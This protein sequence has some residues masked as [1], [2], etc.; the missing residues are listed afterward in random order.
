MNTRPPH[1]DMARHLYTAEQ[2]S[3]L[4]RGGNKLSLL[5]SYFY[6]PPLVYWL[7]ALSFILLGHSIFVAVLVNSI[8]LLI[9]TVAFAS[10]AK[11]VN[12][13]RAAIFALIFFLTL[14]LVG[15]ITKEVQLDLPLSAMVATN[16]AL[17]IKTKNFS[18]YNW[19]LLYGIVFGLGM[20]TK[21]TFIAFAAWPL[22]ISI[23]CILKSQNRREK[24]KNLF[25]ASLLIYGISAPW[26]LHNYYS[27]RIDFG[28][29]ATSAGVRE[30][31]PAVSSLMGLSWYP[32]YILDYYLRLP[33]LL[34]CI[35]SFYLV[36]SKKI[37]RVLSHDLLLILSTAVGGLIVFTFLRNKDIRYIMPIFVG[38]SLIA[39]ITI[40][41][42]ISK[43]QQI[44]AYSLISLCVISYAITSFT[45]IS[46]VSNVKLPMVP[47][48]VWS[49]AGYI[50]GAPAREEW[51]L[52]AAFEAIEE[53]GKAL[54]FIGQDSIWFNDWAVK[55]YASKSNMTIVAV[56]D[57][58]LILDRSNDLPGDTIWSCRALDGTQV[59][60]RKNQP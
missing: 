38:V 4:M 55:Y 1:W 12:R 44:L 2:Y 58:D 60:L 6:Y 29:N 19:S 11:T 14:P 48:T 8:W 42:L 39:G 20:L 52:A 35:A 26:Y 53:D 54:A 27:L 51:C 10:I 3:G 47:I 46:Q 24:L 49:G 30:G 21:W 34:I 7:L 45:T 57:A 40:D 16:L 33:W 18:S 15:S 23:I 5:L 31:D 9:L 32:R 17:I 50:T 13:S 37:K 41:I 36:L 59:S 22:L 43:R 56:Q 25:L 28:A